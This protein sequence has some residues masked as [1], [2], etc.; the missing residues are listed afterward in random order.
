MIGFNHVLVGSIIAVTVKQPVA[1][2]PI[3]LA[4]HYVCDA[5]PHMGRIQ[6]FTPWKK[7]FLALLCIDAV[8]CVSILLV[9]L[10]VW[11]ELWF[12]LLIGTAFATLPD[13]LWIH[14]HKAGKP[15][16]WIYR[17]HTWVQWGERPYGWTYE[18]VYAGLFVLFLW[19]LA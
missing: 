6:A 3:A 2:A 8:V 1:V 12:S 9:G 7:T 18:A 17:F 4:S 13:F 19:R 5:T 16:W 10:R 15:R 11:P 14:Y